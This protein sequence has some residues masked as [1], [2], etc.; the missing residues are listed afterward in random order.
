MIPVTQTKVVVKNSDGVI[1]QNGNCYAAVIASIMEL[2]IT[3]VP[4][5]EV[6]FKFDKMWQ[7]TMMAFI[8]LSGWELLTCNQ[9]KVFHHGAEFENGEQREDFLANCRDKY[10]LVSGQ[11][12]RGVQHICIYQNG[13]LVHDPHPTKEGLLTESVF[14]EL[15]RKTKP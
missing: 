9:F 12:A 3:E 11:S 4:N 6:F 2:P 15:I 14:Q 7:E 8:D 1:V 5:V 10:Y 13:K